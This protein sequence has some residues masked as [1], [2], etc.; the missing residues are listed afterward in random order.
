MLGNKINSYIFLALSIALILYCASTNAP[1]NWLPD[2]DGL[3][4]N[5]YG[6]WIELE[7]YSRP[8][9]SAYLYGEL[10][11]FSKDTVF[12][13]N[14]TF[15]TIALS[16]I[17]SGRIASY[18]SNYLSMSGLVA[19]G[20]IST[21]SH[22]YFSLLT[23]PLW[24]IGGSITTAVRSHEPIVDFKNDEYSGFS[25]FAR[26]PQGLPPAMNRQQIKMHR[27]IKK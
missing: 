1:K 14:N 10:I 27:I 19:L 6:S 8:G 9:R 3:Q 16:D 12:I 2:P 23:A 24:L 11:A 7:Y 18:Q 26:Y 15:H 4:T 20:I 22:G 17:K 13:A 25:Q 21:L 5:V